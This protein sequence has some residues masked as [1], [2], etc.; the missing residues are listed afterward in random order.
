[1]LEEKKYDLAEGVSLQF[2]SDNHIK[3]LQFDTPKASLNFSYGYEFYYSYE[4]DGQ[5]SGAYISRT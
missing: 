2:S 4:K 3:N 5:K 1:L